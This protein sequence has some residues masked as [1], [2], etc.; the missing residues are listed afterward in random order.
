MAKSKAGRRPL[1]EGGR[2][3]SLVICLP[4]AEAER[5]RAMAVKD[6]RSMSAILRRII[7]EHLT[8]VRE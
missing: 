5:I 6:D 1:G 8:Q 2:A 3:V 4:P 7:H